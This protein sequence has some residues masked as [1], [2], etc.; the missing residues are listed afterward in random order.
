M[1]ASAGAALGVVIGYVMGDALLINDVIEPG[2]STH[3]APAVVGA[4]GG[5]LG[6]LIGAIAGMVAYRHQ[7]PASRE[8]AT[9]LAIAAVVVV[10]GAAL[11]AAFMVSLQ[12]P[13]EDPRM[14]RLH[15]LIWIDAGLAV[16]TLL[17]LAIRRWPPVV[18]ITALIVVGVGAAAFAVS[19]F[20]PF[21]AGCAPVRD[22]T[23]RVGF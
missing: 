2:S 10:V 17:L 21:L 12:D 16:V 13:F 18:A 5:G 14:F 9:G 7:P 8:E 15:R 19:Q 11:L 22:G 6:W 1:T 3:M 23:C 20:L 4:L